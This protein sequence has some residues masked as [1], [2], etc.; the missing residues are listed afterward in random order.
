MHHCTSII[1]WKALCSTDI[2]T[3]ALLGASFYRFAACFSGA[4]RWN[5]KFVAA[6]FRSWSSSLI[7]S[8]FSQYP[9]FISRIHATPTFKVEWVSYSTNGVLGNLPANLKGLNA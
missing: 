4:Y 6:N 3:H 9:S 5:V 7:G 1:Y 2:T 8:S